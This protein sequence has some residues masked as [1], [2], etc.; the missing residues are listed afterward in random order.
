M[1]NILAE[2]ML[3]FGPKNLSE[4]DRINLQRLM[5]A[6]IIKKPTWIQGYRTSDLLKT[7]TSPTRMGNDPLAPDVLYMYLTQS[8]IA[9]ST[10]NSTK[11]AFEKDKFVAQINFGNKTGKMFFAG[12]PGTL[13]S[14]TG[15][16]VFTPGTL[17][18]LY[19][20]SSTGFVTTSD[21]DGDDGL[22]NDL[23]EYAGSTQN[24]IVTAVAVCQA[25]AGVGQTGIKSYWETVKTIVNMLADMQLTTAITDDDKST[26][27]SRASRELGSTFSFV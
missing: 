18:K 15:K 27:A 14:A 20:F 3:R 22:V 6:E 11:Y 23:V 19:T 10:S 8:S 26:V 12:I 21:V 13:S 24:G 17:L 2:N 9:S 5:E 7:A 4:S 16:W 1:K 25:I